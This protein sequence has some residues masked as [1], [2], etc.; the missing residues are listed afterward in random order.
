[1]E[2][3][4][5]F[6]EKMPFKRLA[7]KH[8]PAG[9]RSKVPFLETV[10]IPYANQIVCGLVFVL[11]LSCIPSGGGGSGHRD[12]YGTWQHSDFIHLSYQQKKLLIFMIVKL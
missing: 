2:K 11:L 3:I 10:V 4:K 9:A 7:E 8:I 5:A 12:F 6:F 1:M